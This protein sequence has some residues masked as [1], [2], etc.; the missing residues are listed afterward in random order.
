M[1]ILI[2]LGGSSGV[3]VLLTAFIVIGR[4]IFKQVSATEENTVA[5]RELASSVG[6]LK[7]MFNNHEVRIAVLEDRATRGEDRATKYE[8]GER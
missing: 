4:G 5:V 2:A 7:N 8:N 6:E 3:I 1:N